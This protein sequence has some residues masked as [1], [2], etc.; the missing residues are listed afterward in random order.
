VTHHDAMERIWLHCFY[1]ELR[2][3]P[4][5]HPCMLTE[6]PCNPKANREKMA[7]SMFEVFNVPSFSVQNQAVLSLYASGRTTGIV[8]ASGDGV[9]HTVPI[10]EGFSMPHAAERI[11]LAGRDLTEYLMRRLSEAG[12]KFF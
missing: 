7:I 12:L 5:D 3:D 10:Y 11:D 8:I 4:E 1:S 6:A 2:K 9:T